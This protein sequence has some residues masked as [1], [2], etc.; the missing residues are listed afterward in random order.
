MDKKV[1]LV[2]V[3]EF[4]LVELK[5]DLKVVFFWGCV[6]WCFSGSVLD[7]IV[8]LM[9]VVEDCGLFFFDVFN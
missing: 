5:I 9:D 2:F 3:K 1:D 4:E 8:N 7:K 6:I